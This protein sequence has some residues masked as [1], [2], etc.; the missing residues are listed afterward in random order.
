MTAKKKKMT[1]I[2]V[3]VFRILKGD[4]I[5]ECSSFMLIH[6]YLI[7]YSLNKCLLSPYSVIRLLL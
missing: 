2:T 1:A 4:Y 3:S 7:Y 6:F 5:P